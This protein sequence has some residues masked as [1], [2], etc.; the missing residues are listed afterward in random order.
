MYGRLD[1]KEKDFID[2][3]EP[4]NIQSRYPEEKYR[5]FHTLDADR[6]RRLLAQTEELYQW[7]RTTL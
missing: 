5:I 3:L 6:C 4:L 1:D 7:I 2:S